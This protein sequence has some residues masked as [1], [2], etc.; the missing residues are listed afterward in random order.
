M[1][2]GILK[3]GIPPASLSPQFGGYSD[4][5]QTMIG[6]ER[7]YRVFDVQAGEL[8]PSVD[9][10]EAYLVTGSA[11]GVYDDLPWIAP[12]EAFLR[13][14]KGKVKLVGVCF[15]HQ[16]MAQA[17]GGRA[18]K[19]AKGWGLGL[20]TYQL[21]GTE[22][23]MDGAPTIAVAVSHQDQVTA[24]PPGARVLGGNAFC[25]NGLIDYGDGAISMQCHPE[26][27]PDYAKALLELRRERPDVAPLAPAAIASLDAP[28]D[29]ARVGGWIRAF[30]FGPG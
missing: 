17:F 27:S 26:F 2:L 13:E 7:D 22:P 15:G 29:R 20:Q 25:P 3:T 16:I 23:W 30:L 6:P 12:L 24:V 19:S 1:T 5:F 14:A 10:C 28:N 4:M 21:S 8:P 18:E 11:A 9:A